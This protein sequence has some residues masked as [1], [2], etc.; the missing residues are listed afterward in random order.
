VVDEFPDAGGTV[1]TV[2]VGNG[3]PAA[4]GFTGFAICT[5]ATIG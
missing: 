2:R 4:V 5:T 1:W 3:G